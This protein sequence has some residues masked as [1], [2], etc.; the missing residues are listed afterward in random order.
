[1]DK[2]VVIYSNPTWPDCLAAEKFLSQKGINYLNK[3][4][5][6]D[7]EARKELVEKYG[8]MATP[9]IVINGEAIMGFAQNREKIEGLLSWFIGS[10]LRNT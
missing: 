3:D 5:L 10:M 8:R 4:I 9:T 1:M 7:P 6:N 2:S